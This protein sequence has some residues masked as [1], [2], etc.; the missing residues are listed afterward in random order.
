MVDQ[1]VATASAQMIPDPAAMRETLSG[2]S[3]AIGYLPDHLLDASLREISIDGMILLICDC[4]F[5]RSLLELLKEK[6]S[7]G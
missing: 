3:A 1:P 7:N 4:R 6:P 5:W 2:D